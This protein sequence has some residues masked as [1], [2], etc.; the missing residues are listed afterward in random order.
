MNNKIYLEM[1][2][3]WQKE[4]HGAYFLSQIPQKFI[5]LWNSSHRMHTESWQISYYKRCKKHHHKLAKMKEN[6]WIRTGLVYL[7][8]SCDGGKVSPPWELPSK[9]GKSAGKSAWTDK[10]LQRLRGEYLK[11]E[12]TINGIKMLYIYESQL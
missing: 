6:K 5:Y 4:G 1:G 9:A 8:G 11:K 12:I 3:R 2:W 10:E 7:G